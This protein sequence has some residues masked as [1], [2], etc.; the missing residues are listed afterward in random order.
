M[1]INEILAKAKVVQASLEQIRR[2]VAGS[3][4]F[5]DLVGSTEYKTKHPKEDEWLP[6]LATFLTSATS[7]IGVRGRV[8]KYIGDEV[9]AFFDEPNSV[10]DAEHAAE[11][12]LQF[13]ER[14]SEY[15]F[16]VKIALDYGSVSMI[17]FVTD[18]NATFG[19]QDPQG[20]IVDRC[21]RIMSKAKP[22]SVLCSREFKEASRVAA[23][24]R[25]AG[26][27]HGKGVRGAI[28]IWQLNFEGHPVLQIEDEI[29]ADECLRRLREVQEQLR[30]VKNLQSGRRLRDQ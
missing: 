9:M 15:D 13:C 1:D 14:Y 24:W 17:D 4:M 6:R 25:K 28:E 22:N 16:R 12:I 19:R 20:L 11:Q 18:K 29:S 27:F 7:I 3:V 21:A 5:V 30:E 23:R 26:E 2:R 8:V 10:M